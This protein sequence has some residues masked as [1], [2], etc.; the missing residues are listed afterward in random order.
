MAPAPQPDGW[1]SSSNA[2][3]A[4]AP[5]RDLIGSNRASVLLRPGGSPDGP[6]NSAWRVV[7]NAIV[8]PESVR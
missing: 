3:D 4:S 5:Y 7:V 2:S 8:E 6:V 1:A